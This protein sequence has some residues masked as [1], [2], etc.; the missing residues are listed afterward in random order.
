MRSAELDRAVKI[1]REGG[2]IA[3]ATEGVWGLACDPWNEIAVNRILEI[4]QR[5]IQQG[6]IVIG[7]EPSMFQE[8]LDSVSPKMR[9]KVI[10]SWPGH[11]TWVLPTR[12]FP[13]WVT[14]HRASIAARIP[15]H[16]QTRTLA[17]LFG[18]PI[19]STS[20]NVSG[21]EPATTMKKVFLEFASAVD[22]V[23]PGEIGSVV[24]PSRILDAV[25]ENTIR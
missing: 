25:T 14:G 15:D 22:L 9:N 13:N 5:S 23:V 3:H 24:G 4:K 16:E 19:I 17:R 20:A 1:L 8:E 12:R 18:K 11:V 10:V 7:S 6:L 21:K 2:V